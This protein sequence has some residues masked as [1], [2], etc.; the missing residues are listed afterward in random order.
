[1]FSVVTCSLSG[2]DGCVFSG[3]LWSLCRVQDEQS[4][5]P[6]SRRGPVEGGE[7]HPS[8]LL[9][10]TN[11]HAT[12]DVDPKFPGEFSDNNNDLALIVSFYM[13]W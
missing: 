7:A 11:I 13:L 12:G 3:H 1:M 9:A 8:S 10:A 2:P 6:G 4:R 5:F